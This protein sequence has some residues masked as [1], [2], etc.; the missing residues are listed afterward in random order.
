MTKCIEV[1]LLAIRLILSD[2][3]STVYLNDVGVRGI[4]AQKLYG[5]GRRGD[6]LLA[7]STSGNSENILYAAVMA[8]A[9]GI[10]VVG[11]TGNSGGKMADI[12]DVI[13]RVPETETY[14]VQEL[15][16]PVYHCL[17]LMLEN[18]FFS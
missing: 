14:K 3:L 13:I 12:S 6:A 15:H 9:L 5:Y 16:M 10:K 7:I 17:C 4:F 1:A 8:K 18:R 2:S 11:L